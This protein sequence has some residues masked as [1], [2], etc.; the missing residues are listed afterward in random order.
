M[1]RDYHAEQSMWKD[2]NPTAK[3]QAMKLT[4]NFVMK[5]GVAFDPET[6]E[7]VT[8][9]LHVEPV[10]KASQLKGYEVKKELRQH[11]EANGGY[12]F[13][14]F[15]Q[16]QAIEQRFPSLTQ[17]D[18]ARLMF[19]GTY[20]TYNEGKPNHCYLAHDNGV[21]IDKRALGVLLGMRSRN[22]YAEFYGKLIDENILAELPDGLAVNPT[23]FYR[24]ENLTNVKGDY[25]YTRLFRKTVRELYAK[26]DGRSI[27]KLGVIYAVLPYVNFNY[28]FL[29][30]N[31]HE[32]KDG[33]IETLKLK[34]LADALG[35]DDY[36]HLIKT[37]NEIKFDDKPVF[38]FVN[39]AEDR[40]SSKVIVNP[41]VIYA[42]NGKHLKAIK[43][44][45]N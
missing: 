29:C 14:F 37:M 19:I 9:R 2:L 40:R 34:D 30:R 25:Q 24:G 44:L 42:G 33:K 28:N 20:A 27:K 17:S 12:V 13:A 18:L 35:Y 6:G 45:F 16:L 8:D 26:F 3:R 39:N 32:V 4:Y 7:I 23:V 22:K 1:Y 41:D 21:R 11:E 36:K 43:I 10:I 38:L 31:P 15:Y 5:D